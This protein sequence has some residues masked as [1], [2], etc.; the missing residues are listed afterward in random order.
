MFVE[1]ILLLSRSRDYNGY[2]SGTRRSLNV[3]ATE[4]PWRPTLTPY[5]W[6]SA[7]RNITTGFRVKHGMVSNDSI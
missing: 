5:R 3:I 7:S 2:L 6:K 1:I 4:K